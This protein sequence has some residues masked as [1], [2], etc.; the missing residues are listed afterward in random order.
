MAVLGID[1]GTR[2]IGLAIS[3]AACGVALPAGRLESRGRARDV[4][5][6]CALARER[7]V[8]EVV[9]GLPL[10][11]DGRRGEAARAAQGFAE[12]LRDASGLPVE[13]FDERLSSAE[14]ERALRASG[15]RARGVKARRRKLDA[16]DEVAATILLRAY[17]ELRR[18]R[19]GFVGV[20]TK[21][22]GGREK[23]TGGDAVGVG[24]K[25]AS[26]DAKKTCARANSVGENMGGVR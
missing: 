3:D 5:A 7:G 13:T 6:L 9:V 19:G 16:R 18:A 26:V 17:L 25:S 1:W 12:A 23:P 14:A 22:G 20:N 21:A 2:R 24:A 15:A 10:L 8:A 4:A 11:M